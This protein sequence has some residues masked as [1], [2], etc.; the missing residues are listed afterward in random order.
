MLKVE[1]HA[2]ILQ[3]LY[4]EGFV[5]NENLVKELNVSMVTIRRDLKSLEKQ[6]LIKLEHGGASDI[7]YFISGFEPLYNTKV[8]MNLKEKKEIGV[9]A[10]KLIEE[11]EIIILDSGTT[12]AEIAKNIR[13]ERFKNLTIITND[14][15]VAKE[16]CSDKNLHVLILGGTLRP[17]YFNSYGHYT[18]SMLKNLKV[19]KYFMGVDAVG[20]K[21]GVYNLILNEVTIKR[22]MISISNQVIMVSDNTK[23]GKEAPYKVCDFK[24]IDAVISDQNISKVYCELFNSLNIKLFLPNKSKDERRNEK[25]D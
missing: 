5:S 23:F 25:N 2:K 21:N 7:N 10:V 16:L 13:K 19:N 3:F 18:E 17:S 9:E 1:R 14:L 20:E 15:I 22:L 24:E 4:K 6:G 11:G 12:T 8:F